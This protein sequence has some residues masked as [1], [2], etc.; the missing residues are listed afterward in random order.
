M[1][2]AK[3]LKHPDKDIEKAI[4]YAE[5]KGW[6]F[7]D[8][9]KSAHAWGRLLCPLHTR[10]GCKMSVWST[11]RNSYNHARQIERLVNKCIH[12]DSEDEK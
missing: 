9:G 2:M 1:V 4:L 7:K 5:E 6:V 12:E 11:P 10:E 3:R 8:S